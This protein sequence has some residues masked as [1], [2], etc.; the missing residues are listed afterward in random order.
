[1]ATYDSTRARALELLRAG[2]ITAAEAAGF[3]E[4]T[5]Q[6]VRD[7]CRRAG[8]DSVMA[9][10]RYLR[11]LFERPRENKTPGYHIT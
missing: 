5:R 7:M 1:M 4:I 9:R 3:L 6:S 2:M 8:I 11:G 10:H